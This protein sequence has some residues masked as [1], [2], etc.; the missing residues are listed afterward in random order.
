MIGVVA[1]IFVGLL[2]HGFLQEHHPGMAHLVEK[3]A[4]QLFGWRPYDHR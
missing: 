4:K 1:L 3:S 2:V